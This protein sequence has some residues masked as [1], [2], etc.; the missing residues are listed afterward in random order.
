MPI[1]LKSE[2]PTWMDSEYVENTPESD[3]IVRKYVGL[4]V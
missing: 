1:S 2:L 4:D 3:K